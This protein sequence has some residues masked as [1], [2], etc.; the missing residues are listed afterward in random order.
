MNTRATPFSYAS[1]AQSRAGVSA[2]K[3]G[4]MSAQI[5]FA[6]KD[7]CQQ[8]VAQHK[9]ER[10][11]YI[12]GGRATSDPLGFPKNSE[13][14][15]F[16]TTCWIGMGPFGKLVY[17]K[18]R[19]GSPSGS[20]FMVFAAFWGRTNMTEGTYENHLI[21]PMDRP[22]MHVVQK[23]VFSRICFSPK[24]KKCTLQKCNFVFKKVSLHF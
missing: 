10:L 2:C 15:P 18:R 5:V 21:H 14:A 19:M 13:W 17:P 23:H 8:F 11:Q 3:S 20:F 7:M 4:S 12:Q 24:E 16:G 1:H 9:D 22:R 6:S